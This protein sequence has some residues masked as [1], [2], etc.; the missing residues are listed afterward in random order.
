MTA[1]VSATN[2]VG[3]SEASNAGNGA[4][5]LRLSDAP[6]TLTNNAALTSSSQIA[7]TWSPGVEEGGASIIDYRLWYDQ[8]QGSSEYVTLESGITTTAFTMVVDTI[9]STYAFKVQSRTTYGLSEFSN[10][11]SVLAAEAPAKP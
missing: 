6:L 2:A 9:G 5:L 10:V 1:K 3:Q 7:L 8:G 4:I 11:V